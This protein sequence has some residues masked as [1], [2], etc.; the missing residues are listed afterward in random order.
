MRAI[1]CPSGFGCAGAPVA[2][3]A[4][5]ARTS[6]AVRARPSVHQDGCSSTWT[7]PL[8]GTSNVGADAVEFSTAISRLGHETRPTAPFTDDVWS[9][10]LAGGARALIETIRHDGV[11]VLLIEHDVKLVMGLCDRVTVLD[12]GKMIAVG[13]PGEVQR[14]AA[15]ID[16]RHRHLI[17]DG[18][19]HAMIDGTDAGAATEPPIAV[20]TTSCTSDCDRP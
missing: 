3:V 6:T 5:T 8:D 20:R 16:A 11:T 10:L 2:A 14:N 15:V 9:E 18:D 1:D 17:L 19:R 4:M 7:L 13:A 12:Y